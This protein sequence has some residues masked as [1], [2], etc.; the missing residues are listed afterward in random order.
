MVMV[1]SSSLKVD[2]RRCLESMRWLLVFIMVVTSLAL[3]LALPANAQSSASSYKFY[4]NETLRFLY[5]VVGID[6]SRYAI[7]NSSL[8]DGS[9]ALKLRSS[10][11]GELTVY[12]DFVGDR[13]YGVMIYVDKPP[14]LLK[15]EGLAR[16]RD[17]ESLKECFKNIIKRYVACYGLENELYWEIM[18]CI[19]S[20]N[21]SL[22]DLQAKKVVSIRHG[23]VCLEVLSSGKEVSMYVRIVDENGAITPRLLGVTLPLG[24]EPRFIAFYDKLCFTRIIRKKPTI[25]RDE[26][27]R[28][29]V[30]LA[31]EYFRREYGVDVS[32]L[33]ARAECRLAYYERSRG[34]LCPAWDVVIYF[35]KPALNET[36]L[37]QKGIY[38]FSVLIWADTG[39]VEVASP[40]GYFTAKD[41]G[42]LFINAGLY[43]A[44][45][46]ILAV[47]VLT[48]IIVGVIAILK[49][50]VSQ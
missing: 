16:I 28:R 35:N 6:A 2:C 5:K 12:A 21:V 47:L 11:G 15:D 4:V 34:V 49:T 29:A 20:L 32:N 43:A 45:P 27:L 40:I 9:C 41:A 17:T 48:S 37:L 33:I 7:V 25:S 31:E 10:S 3:I 39:D 26:A 23:E 24:G 38:G 50:R 44:L 1:I 13:V 18:K 30:A 42:K 22:R 36:G 46:M 14:L 8:I 19:D